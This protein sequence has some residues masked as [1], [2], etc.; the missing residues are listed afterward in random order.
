MTSGRKPT[1]YL[2][3]IDKAPFE[4]AWDTRMIPTQADVAVRALVTFHNKPGLIYRTPAAGGL[5]IPERPNANVTLHH[6]TEL[7]AP[8]WVR[9]GQRKTCVIEL[10]HDPASIENAELH[11]VVWTGGAGTI[12]DYFT[13]NG[14]PLPVAEGEDH[15]TVYSRMPIA[16]ALLRRGKNEISLSSDTKHHGIEILLPGPALVVRSRTP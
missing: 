12:K 3:S 11:V 6:A 15:R 7:P 10:D 14:Q 5:G 13:L 4:L 1:G 9:D 8:F 16:P 2:G